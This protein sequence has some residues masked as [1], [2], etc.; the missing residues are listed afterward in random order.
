MGNS[1]GI[2]SLKGGVGKTSAVVALGAAIANFGK[3][4]VLI[5]AN[6]SAPNLGIHLDI[7]NP[8]VTLHNVLSKQA[9]ITAAIQQLE[10]FD[11][12]PSAVLSKLKINPFK[13]KDKVKTLKGRYDYV[14]IDSS[15]SANHETLAAM[16]ASD[17]IL[18]VTTPDYSTLSTT[19]TAVHKAKQRGTP[20]KG[21]IL[22]KVRH[23]DF[24]LSLEEIE[25][26]AGIPV[27]A[28]IPDDVNILRAQAKFIPSTIFKPKSPASIEYNK[29]AATIVGEKYKP[30]KLKKLFGWINPKQE[31]IN[32]EIY[33]ETVFK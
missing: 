23:K 19:L 22:N 12:I 16:L 10:N 7:L 1:L 14:L 3:K 13:L 5:D 21:L 20:I 26:A 6:F 8:E 29:L 30:A 32:R 33:Y 9:N 31:E 24:E 25:D 15:P 18:A 11:I 28:V 2:V 4:V 27:L 17:E